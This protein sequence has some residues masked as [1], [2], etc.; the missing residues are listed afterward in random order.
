MH[1]TTSTEKLFSGSPAFFGGLSNERELIPLI[2]D[3]FRR[4]DN[5]YTRLANLIFFNGANMAVWPFRSTN[6]AERIRQK[7]C[8]RAVL[9][10]FDLS[11]EDKEALGGWMLSEML[12]EVPS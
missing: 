12:T 10:G 8:L 5:P 4:H 1:T 9:S 3:Q 6:E 11:H 7:R 2:P